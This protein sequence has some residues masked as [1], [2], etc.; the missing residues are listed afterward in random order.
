MK[1]TI[2]LE[3]CMFIVLPDADR[4]V[5]VSKWTGQVEVLTINQTIAI[6]EG[7]YASPKNTAQG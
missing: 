2:D 3:T 4:V 5:F 1:L 7:I 6:I